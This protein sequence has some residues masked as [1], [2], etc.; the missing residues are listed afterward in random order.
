MYG[1]CLDFEKQIENVL[2]AKLMSLN[3]PWF[4]I[5][6][7]DFSEDNM[8]KLGD[9]DKNSKEGCGR[10]VVYK[11]FKL[12]HSYT[13][14]CNY[15]S[16][17]SL[18]IKYEH[19]DSNNNILNP[20]TFN[21]IG[22]SIGIS[23]AYLSGNYSISHFSLENLQLEVAK[24]LAEQNPYK[25]DADIRKASKSRE[26]LENYLNFKKRYKASHRYRLVHLLNDPIRPSV[27]NSKNFLKKIQPYENRFSIKESESK[28]TNRSC[29]TAKNINFTLRKKNSSYIKKKKQNI[30]NDLSFNLP[31]RKDMRFSD[32]IIL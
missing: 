27:N 15:H 12:T 17:K 8:K 7:C 32:I 9:R 22:Q 19:T 14:E 25:Q 24:S 1:N 2:F 20:E 4:S 16:V 5:E 11:T 18:N 26:N 10:V 21:K 31:Y 23:L 3:C 29:I 13:F 28:Q 6:G 30:N